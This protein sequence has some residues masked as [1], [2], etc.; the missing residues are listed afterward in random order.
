LIERNLILRF[1]F[2]SVGVR[3][4]IFLRYECCVPFA[5]GQPDFLIFS[6]LPVLLALQLI[7][8]LHNLFFIKKLG[9]VFR[10]RIIKTC[11]DISVI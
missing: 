8:K 5:E 11:P 9:E 2:A 7:G 10:V 4:G 6:Y 3:F 1:G